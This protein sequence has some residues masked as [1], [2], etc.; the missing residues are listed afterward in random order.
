V[1]IKTFASIPRRFL[2]FTIDYIIISSYLA[3][4]ILISVLVMHDALAQTL[5]ADPVTGQVSGFFFVTLPVI[6]YFSLM[7]S[8][9]WRATPGKRILGLTV[10]TDS[11]TRL[12]RAR[13]F[14]RSVI[15]FLPWELSHSCL[16][17][18]PGW[19]R[20]PHEPPWIVYVGFAL[21]WGLLGAYILNAVFSS[22]HQT[23]Y[24]RLLCCIVI[25]TNKAGH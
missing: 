25:R 2:A 20:T 11:D 4:L 7:E 23:L 17:R 3:V 18:I 6:L 8:S 9:S 1:I 10:V 19:P 21:V 16:W 15:K 12:T 24:D 5:F 14:A 13:A 22:R